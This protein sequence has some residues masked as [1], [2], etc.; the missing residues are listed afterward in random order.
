MHCTVRSIR[1]CDMRENW[2]LMRISALELENRGNKYWIQKS[3]ER[4]REYPKQV[5]GSSSSSLFA[6]LIGSTSPGLLGRDI[7][8]NPICKLLFI[9]WKLCQTQALMFFFPPARFPSSAP[10]PESLCHIIYD[11]PGSSWHIIKSRISFLRRPCPLGIGRGSKGSG[12]LI[13]GAVMGL[14]RLMIRTCRGSHHAE[15]QEGASGAV[16][17]G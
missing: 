16:R 5:T 4:G 9:C 8:T 2:G 14:E 11:F 17:K 13:E 15:R 7:T 12:A 6:G 10:T 1:I 3:K